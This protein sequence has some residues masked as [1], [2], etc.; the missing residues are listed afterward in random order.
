MAERMSRR[1]RAVGPAPSMSLR[2]PRRTDIVV[3]PLCTVP[4]SRTRETHLALSTSATGRAVVLQAF[5]RVDT[6]DAMLPVGRPFTVFRAEIDAIVA[7]LAAAAVAL[8]A[9]PT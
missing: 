3:T 6:S 9:L 4:V 2:P 1:R 7:G 8:D 5:A